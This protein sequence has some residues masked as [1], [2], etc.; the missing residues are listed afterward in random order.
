MG[1]CYRWWA[2]FEGEGEARMRDLKDLILENKEVTYFKI[3]TVKTNSFQLFFV[4]KNLETIRNTDTKDIK[5]T[6][7]VLHDGKLGDSE[8]TVYSSNTEEEIIEKINSSVEK[9][10]LVSNSPYILPKKEEETYSN[11]TNFNDY[12]LEEI[13]KVTQEAVFKADCYKDG[14][15]N[16]LEIFITKYNIEVENSNGLKKSQITYDA[17]IEAIP[18]WN[19]ERESVELYEQYHFNT[20]DKEKITA[21][22]DDKMKAVKARYEATK[23]DE[24]KEVNILLRSSE[25]LAMINELAWDINYATIYSKSNKYQLGDNLQENAQGDLLSVTVKAR[26]PG[27]TDSR[28]FDN[29]GVNIEDVKVIS[30]GK[31]V[32]SFGNNQYAQYLNLKPTGNPRCTTLEGG[33]KKEEELKASPYLE[34]VS[35]SGI[36]VDKFNDYIGGEV[37]LGYY[38]DGKGVKPI[39]GISISGS[40]SNVL[41]NM[42]LSK[43]CIQNGSYFGPK[44]MLLKGMKVN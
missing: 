35:M 23:P 22:I 44:L 25:I 8:F 28:F 15:I 41:K 13:A 26:I 9:A 43:D 17:M 27:S 1:S 40:L 4:H 7:Y 18:T 16:A 30:N 6:I 37:R 29:D 39:T 31:F 32:N 42:Y 24:V 5:V 10:K 19:G 34:C 36:Q 20:L 11:D 38:F 2:M 33:K 21:E 3:N 12:S 14:S